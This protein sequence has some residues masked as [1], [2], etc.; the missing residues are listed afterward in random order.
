MKEHQFSA[1]HDRPAES[2]A[3]FFFPDFGRPLL[4]PLLSKAGAGVNAVAMRPEK[5]RPIC[6][7]RFCRD[8]SNRKQ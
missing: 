6:L 7:G 1:G 5:L 8:G 2:L 3:E 4:G